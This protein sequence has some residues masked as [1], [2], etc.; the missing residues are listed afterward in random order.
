MRASNQPW[1][2]KHCPEK[3]EDVIAQEGAV[4][5]LKSY[6]ND[7]KNQKKKSILIYGPSG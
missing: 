4:S 5:V 3:G 1:T 7:Y 2:R 6:I